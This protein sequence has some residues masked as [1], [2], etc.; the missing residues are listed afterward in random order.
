MPE[1]QVFQ[2]HI[3]EISLNMIVKEDDSDL[4]KIPLEYHEFVKIFSKIEVDKLPEH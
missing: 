1:I 4:T 3:S 2:L